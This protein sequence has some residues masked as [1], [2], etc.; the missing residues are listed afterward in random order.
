MFIYNPGRKFPWGAFLL[1]LLWINSDTVFAANNAG[2]DIRFHGTLVE[3]P[4]CTIND[5]K[6]FD[7]NFDEIGVNKIDGKNYLQSVNY[8]LSCKT[9][10]LSWNMYLGITGQVASF[11]TS[12]IQST[13][14]DLAIHMLLNGKDFVINKPLLVDLNN[15]PILQAVPVKNGTLVEGAFSASATL[16]V[17]YQ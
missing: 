7:V 15:L 3:P 1:P 10:N 9:N 8:S 5:G 11:D 13:V 6:V 12:A 14:P 2:T 4:P 17:E 16:Y